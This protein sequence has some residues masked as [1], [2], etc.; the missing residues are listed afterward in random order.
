M[1]ISISQELL[2]EY[3]R[4]FWPSLRHFANG[5]EPIIFKGHKPIPEYFMYICPMCVSNY[6]IFFSDGFYC[7]A[8]FDM[9]HFPPQ[10]AGGTLKA[11]VCKPCNSRAGYEFDYATKEFLNEL[12][13]NKRIPF[14]ILKTRHTISDVV[15]RHTGTVVIDERGEIEFS[16]KKN[17]D[18]RIKPLDEFIRDRLH[19]PTWKAEVTI[20]TTDKEKLAKALLKAAY[21]TCFNHWGYDFIFSDT[22]QYMRETLAGNN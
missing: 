14:S 19:T 18:A 5:Y 10:N 22:A 20:P 4:L 12:G 13:F 17:P 7:S 9:D 21:L 16:L 6:M 3:I 2:M 15:G 8:E 1:N 11:I